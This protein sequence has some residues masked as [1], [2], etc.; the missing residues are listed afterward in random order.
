MG[1]ECAAEHDLFWE[2]HDTLFN[3]WRGANQG[4]FSYPA[5]QGFASELGIDSVQFNDCMETGRGF[6]GVKADYD[7]AASK[8]IQGTPTVF[9]NDQRISG[10]YESFRQ[11]I[12]QAIAAAQ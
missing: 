11:A 4:H 2:F 12:E 5:I 3:N 10:D 8:N 6:L 7:T 9:V 1:A